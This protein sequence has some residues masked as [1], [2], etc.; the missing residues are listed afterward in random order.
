MA[1]TRV[2]EQLLAAGQTSGMV[3]TNPPYCTPHSPHALASNA[4]MLKRRILI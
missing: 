3:G 4:I 2:P 1:Q